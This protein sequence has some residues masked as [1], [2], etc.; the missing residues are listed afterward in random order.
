MYASFIDDVREKNPL[1]HN[2]TNI[3]SAHFSANG[4]LAIG[5]S[6]FMSNVEGEMAQVAK[7]SS[8]LVINMGGLSQGEVVAMIDAGQAM[9]ALAK[10]VVLDPVGIGATPYRQEKGA[11][12]LDKI[13]FSVIRG[14][15]G[16]IA[17]LIGIKWQS[18]GV[19]AGSG[20]TADLA[21]MAK[22][23]AK[24]FNCITVLS[25]Q[26][27]YVS[28]GEVVVAI[29]NGSSLFPKITASGCLQGA[30]CGAFIAVA[31]PSEYF[32]A[33]VAA[34][35]SYAIAGEQ[36]AQGLQDFEYG[37]FYVKLIDCLA[38]ISADEFNQF[39]K[40]IML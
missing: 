39:A 24:K 7:I 34:C 40:V 16:E 1:V 11:L 22:E 17:H 30:I 12:L 5:A 21:K 26:V 25:G 28:N 8:A 4:L 20:E 27:D 38:K 31:E 6:P 13:R 2:I 14:N 10:P 18:K 36:A 3:V 35:A 15:A 23:C 33:T 37:Q 9:N 29:E 32:S 19:D